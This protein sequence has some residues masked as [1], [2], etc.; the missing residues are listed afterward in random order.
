MSASIKKSLIIYVY[1]MLSQGITRHEDL[2]K[3]CC[4]F[5]IRAF[6]TLIRWG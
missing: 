6:I 4:G 2:K 5:K 1:M 3:T